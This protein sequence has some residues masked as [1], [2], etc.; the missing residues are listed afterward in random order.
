VVRPTIGNSQHQV[1]NI[2]VTSFMY[3]QLFSFLQ[4]LMTL[5]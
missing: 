5:R 1:C 2:V 3:S 4:K